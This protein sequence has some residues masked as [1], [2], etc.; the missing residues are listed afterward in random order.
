MSSQSSTHAVLIGKITGV[1]GVR[2][3]LKALPYA[4]QP[5]DL[6]H[7]PIWMLKHR[8]KTTPF[9]LEKAQIYQE[10]GLLLKLKGIDS[11]ENGR[12]WV[13]AEIYIDRDL[14]PDLAQGHY[15]ADLE[16]LEV[17]TVEGAYLGRVSHL[18]ETGANDVLVVKNDGQELLIPYVPHV[19]MEA[20]LVDNKIIVDWDTDSA[21]ENEGEEESD[22]L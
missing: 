18:F 10:K 22:A 8:Q 20:N 4:D 13:G 12:L 5:Q 1:H 14:M 7:Y 17:Y 21:E 11:P 2:G 16:G 3:M 6:L 9:T 19:I 15:W